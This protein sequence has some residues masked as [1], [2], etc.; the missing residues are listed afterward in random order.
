MTQHTLSA[1]EERLLN[2]LALRRPFW[3][4]VRAK[5]AEFGT[6]T[7]GQF[8]CFQRDIAR[9]EWERSAPKLGGVPV[10]NKF[11]AG[12]K[13]R[14]ATRDEFCP[15]AA[16]AVVG[17]FGYCSDHFESAREAFNEWNAARIAERAQDAAAEST[18]T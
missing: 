7:D 8:E 6:L 10:R 3:G 11:R 17:Q 1:S 4:A 9:V 12:K 14:C 15:Q 16:V 18:G 2:T 13:P 5:Y